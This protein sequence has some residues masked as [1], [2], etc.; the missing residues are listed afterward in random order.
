MENL[1]PFT[2]HPFCTRLSFQT[3]SRT[4]VRLIIAV[5]F[6]YRAIP[7]ERSFARAENKRKGLNTCDN[8]EHKDL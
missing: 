3:V 1:S 8:G 4:I 6:V 5:D 2:K 7:I